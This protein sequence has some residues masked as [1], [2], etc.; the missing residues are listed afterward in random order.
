MMELLKARI[1]N[2]LK[3]RQLLRAKFRQEYVPGEQPDFIENDGDRTFLE[4]ALS[5]LKK[6]LICRI[7]ITNSLLMKW[8]RGCDHYIES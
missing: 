4:K 2:L 3:S 6:N 5:V 8:D 1:E 7:L